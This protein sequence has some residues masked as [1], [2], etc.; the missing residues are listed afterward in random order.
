LKSYLAHDAAGV[1]RLQRTVELGRRLDA[2]HRQHLAE[3]VKR[4]EKYQSFER[5][6]RREQAPL[7]EAQLRAMYRGKP[8]QI[9][10]TFARMVY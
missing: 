5:Q 3:T 6:R 2:H 7:R 8:E 1:Q 4:I 10:D 9:D